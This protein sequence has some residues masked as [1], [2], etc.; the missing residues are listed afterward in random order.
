MDVCSSPPARAP[1]SQLAVE[2]P[3]TEGHWNPPKKDTPGPKRKKKRDGRRGTIT[4]KS[5][6]TPAGWVTHKLENSNTKKSS[7]CCEGSEPH[8]TLPTK[9]HL[10]KLDRDKMLK[11]TKG[12][13]QIT[14]K[15]TTIRLSADFSTET[16]QARRE[17]HD[18]FKVMKGKKLQ[19]RILYPARLSSRF[20]GEIRSFPDKQ[21]LRELSTT[22][23]AL[24]Q[25]LKELL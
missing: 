9:V 8:I 16:L 22:K 12:K 25:M 3:S 11:A 14:Y 2:Q 24:H 23:S 20:D 10:S 6:P 4:T 15:V 7:H 19:L 17:W 18:I 13:Q 21:K 1:K 5:N